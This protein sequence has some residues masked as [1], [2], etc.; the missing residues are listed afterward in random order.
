MKYRDDKWAHDL[1][2]TKE[3]GVLITVDFRTALGV[4]FV[5][6]ASVSIIAY[7]A[8]HSLVVFV[9]LLLGIYGCVKYGNTSLR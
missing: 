9:E 8:D 7:V 3:E 2:L 5:E 4:V 6:V 1:I